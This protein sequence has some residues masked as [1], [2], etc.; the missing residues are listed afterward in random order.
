MELYSGEDILK[1]FHNQKMT[2]SLMILFDCDCCGSG[3]QLD[4]FLSNT[5]CTGL[6]WFWQCNTPYCGINCVGFEWIKLLLRWT[7]WKSDRFGKFILDVFLTN[8]F[9]FRL[10]EPLIMVVLMTS[11]YSLG[12]SNSSSAICPVY[13]GDYVSHDCVHDL[14]VFRSHTPVL[15]T[16]GSGE[17]RSWCYWIDHCSHFIQIWKSDPTMGGK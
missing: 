10:C 12:S 17:T 8:D 6:D 3:F 9:M 2:V 4:G 7:N 14:R 11:S 1:D 13:D 16:T 15:M 5:L